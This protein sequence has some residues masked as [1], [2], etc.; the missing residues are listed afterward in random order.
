MSEIYQDLSKQLDKTMEFL[1]KSDKPKERLQVLRETNARVYGLAEKLGPNNFQ[2][3]ALR[4]EL[5]H[6]EYQLGLEQKWA[7]KY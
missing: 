7:D 4:L 5:M 2:L 3:A 6:R 1:R